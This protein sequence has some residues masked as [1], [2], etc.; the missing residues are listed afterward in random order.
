MTNKTR[1]GHTPGPWAYRER[2][3]GKHTRLP[4][5]VASESPEEVLGVVA[6]VSD[7]ADAQVICAAPDLLAAARALIESGYEEIIADAIN[8]SD[9]EEFTD[10]LAA[11]RKAEGR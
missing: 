4:F 5:I 7:E 9:I 2:R 6:D 1:A 8:R 11:V 10:L 3:A